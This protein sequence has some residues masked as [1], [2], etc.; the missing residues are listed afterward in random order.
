MTTD[1]T[2][3]VRVLVGC[4][5]TKVFDE[6]LEHCRETLRDIFAETNTDTTVLEA[7][8]AGQEP[9]ETMTNA[10]DEHLPPGSAEH[11][12]DAAQHFYEV[13]T[14]EVL[15][16]NLYTAPYFNLKQDF[17]EEYG[18]D[19]VIISAAHHVLQPDESISTYDE[20]LSDFTKQERQEWGVE[21]AS[22]LQDLDWDDVDLLVTLL[23]K[24]YLNPIQSTLD[25]LPVTTVNPFESTSGIGDQMGLLKSYLEETPTP[26][27]EDGDTPG[28]VLAQLMNDASSQQQLSQ[29]E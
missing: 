26:A 1:S 2:Q 23:G 16:K 29:Y 6:E 8:L 19:W 27:A 25:A 12:H 9:I 4:G 20:T 17:S 28:A 10:I 22:Q 14:R 21:T 5:S 18:D 3:T 13:W 15:A 7:F 24:L 11:A